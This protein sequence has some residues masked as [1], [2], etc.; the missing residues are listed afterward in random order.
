MRGRRLTTEARAELWQRW[1]SGQSL[2]EISRALGRPLNSVFG[3]IRA[4]GG[5]PPLLRRRGSLSLTLADREEI[6]RGLSAGASLRSI[7]RQLARPPSTVCREVT[8]NG[9]RSCYRATDADVR[10]WKQARRPKTCKLVR[11]RRLQRVVARKLQADWSPEQ[12]SHWLRGQFA[13]DPR[14]NISHETIYRSLFIQARG[15]LKKELLTHLRLRRKMR[16]SKRANGPT[17]GDIAG[18]VSIRERPAEV[19]DRAVPGHW[20]GDL[21]CGARNSHIAT[22]VERHTRFTM[23]AKVSGKDTETVVAAVA[24]KVRK[25]PLELRRSLTWDRGKE[26]AS[27]QAFSVATDVRVFFCDPHSPWQRG[28]NENTNGLLRQYFPKGTDLSQHS[29]AHLNKIARRLN[30]RPRK[31]LGFITPA[32]KLQAVLR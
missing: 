5:V 14:M 7:A 17:S 16:H 20:E 28:T 2:T 25:L 8:R 18:A 11:F 29:Q 31:T 19:D 3:H 9:G 21:L 30:T 23:L 15:A 32:D 26:M 27:H 4:N 10:S 12:I 6:S 24:K 13:D 22:L 1:K